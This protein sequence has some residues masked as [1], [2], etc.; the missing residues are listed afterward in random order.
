MSSTSLKCAACGGQ[1]RPAG[2]P[3]HLVCVYCGTLATRPAPPTA[4]PAAAPAK[5]AP[6]RAAPLVAA[7]IGAL[8][9]LL[10]AASVIFAVR[11][12]GEGS[13]ERADGSPAPGLVERA[14][15]RERYLWDDVGGAPVPA[16]VAGAPAV[17]G[18]IRTS[19]AD[20]LYIL[21]TDAATLEPR[22]RLGPLGTYSQGYRHTRFAVSGQRVAVSDFRSTLRV[23]DLQT[24]RELRSL[25]LTDR[26]EAIC[27]AE[28]GVVW[29]RQ[30]DER[31]LRVDLE[32][33]ATASGEA[34]PACQTAHELHRARRG[35][36]AEEDQRRL[37]LPGYQ[38]R[39]QLE[40]GS[41]GVAWVVRSPGTPTPYAVGYDPATLA[42]RWTT[43]IPSIDPHLVR[44]ESL[45]P[46]LKD[47]TFYVN[48]G[49][50]DEV[51]HLTAL[52]A[53]TGARRWDLKLRPIFAVD[54]IDGIEAADGYVYVTRTSSLDVYTANGER[55]GT[56]GDDTYDDEL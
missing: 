39:E 21:A 32:T 5:A 12:T 9:L 15:A 10:G 16:R 41:S 17:I 38:T 43:P 46:A 18:R 35:W 22:W 48:Y 25:N 49:E 11:V 29:V 27:P 44:D 36:T 34:P 26:V 13:E 28:A 6:P 55:V 47:G 33:G 1:L 51:W 14:P 4:G 24:G 40:E 54:S 56:I 31:V 53:A 23:L 8:V 20:D 7:A 50:G 19:P 42:V 45:R 52:D 37:E 30:V 2:D 3:D